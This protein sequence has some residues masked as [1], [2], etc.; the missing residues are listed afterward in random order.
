MI[1]PKKKNAFLTRKMRF[2]DPLGGHQEF[3]FLTF[4]AVI[5]HPTFLLFGALT[6]LLFFATDP[7]HNR[8]YVPLWGSAAIWPMAYIIYMSLYAF[9]LAALSV[10]TGKF[11]RL[12]TPTSLLGFL[13]LFPTVYI[14]EVFI[15]DLMSGGTFPSSLQGNYLFY[16]LSVQV[17]EAVFFRYIFPNIEVAEDEDLNADH[18]ENALVDDI[19]HVIIGGERI[20][21]GNIHLIEAREHHVQVTLLDSQ[22]RLRARLGDIVA[23]TSPSDGVQ[24]HRS[25]W[26]ARHAAKELSEEDGR[27]VLRLND[28]LHIPV[29]RTR[30]GE[31]RTWVQ[32]HLSTDP[33]ASSPAE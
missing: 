19:K 15:L 24:T 30:V 27:P 8:A 33:G 21:L 12:R 7:S 31:V 18:L 25:W 11:P 16:F 2:W 13:T 9:A 28:N 32:D 4:L 23:Q 3:S 29:A 1:P 17:C 22:R 6:L 14:S 10:L 26:V 5:R 20:P